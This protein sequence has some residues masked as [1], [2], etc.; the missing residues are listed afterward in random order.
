M[1]SLN[2]IIMQRKSRRM[3]QRLD[4]AGM[5]AAEI[6]G[7]HGGR[8]DFK[9][10]QVFRYP[11]Y[12]ICAGAFT[13][14]DGA[15]QQFDII[16]AN[17]VWEHLDRPYTATRH[18][19]EMLRPGGYFWIAVPFFIPYHGA[20]I[21]CSRWSARGL[22]NLLIEAGFER[23]NITAAQWGNR[24]CA[25]RNLEDDWPPVYDPDID[26]LTNEEDFP[27]V[28]WALAQKSDQ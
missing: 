18:V 12:D 7:K 23:E 26:D 6:S 24:H 1:A 27:L 15:V 8:F 22:K 2:R 4:L 9:S 21:D 28:S 10:Y 20:P 14:A 13:D 16:L 11:K 17:Q 19:L 25:K 5:D 3:L